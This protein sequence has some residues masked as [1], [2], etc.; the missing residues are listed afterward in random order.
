M[1]TVL[2]AFLLPFFLVS[3][4]FHTLGHVHV[5]CNDETVK[6]AKVRNPHKKRTTFILETF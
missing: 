1:L 5:V 6:D 2:K 4:W 3:V